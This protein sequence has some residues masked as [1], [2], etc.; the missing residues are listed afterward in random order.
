MIQNSKRGAEL[1]LNVI[2][3][4]IIILIVLVVVII[5][6]SQRFGAFGR[7]TVDCGAQG[8]FCVTGEQ[9]SVGGVTVSACPAGQAEIKNTNC[10]EG[11]ICCINVFGAADRK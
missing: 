5:I 10:P 8:G 3:I 7:T 1:S 9:R 2:I 6:F 11:Q 4:A